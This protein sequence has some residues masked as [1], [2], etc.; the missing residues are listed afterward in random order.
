M[1]AT[2]DVEELT[3]ADLFALSP[4][5]QA[6]LAAG[7]DVEHFKAIEREA[8]SF[9]EPIAWNEMRTEIAGVMTDALDMKVVEGWVAVWQK[10]KEVKEKVEKSHNSPNTP[11]SCTLLEHSIESTL[12]PY[13]K[14]F[15]GP[16]LVQKID[17]DVTLTT[18][19]DGL[20]LNLKGGS[21]V[22]IQPGRCE[23]SGSIAMYGA[24]LIER[25]LSQLDLPGSIVLKHPIP[26]SAQK[27]LEAEPS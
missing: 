21:I 3:I 2:V 25:E 9:S 11:F 12:H 18:Q 1:N 17:F 10:C 20:I 16:K 27:K 19:I 15:L 23:W 4:E 24:Q 7:L 8:K 13:L 6:K 14:V 26:L 5:N 22:S